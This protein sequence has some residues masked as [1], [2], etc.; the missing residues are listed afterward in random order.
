MIN[1]FNKG[2]MSNPSLNPP[3]RK[4]QHQVH[5]LASI[6]MYPQLRID[7]D[8]QYKKVVYLDYHKVGVSHLV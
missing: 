4:N 7:R 5:R 3:T 8:F 6:S 2:N 1:K